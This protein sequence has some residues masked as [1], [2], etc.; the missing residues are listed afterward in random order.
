M[1]T[2]TDSGIHFGLEIVRVGR[3]PQYVD[4]RISDARQDLVG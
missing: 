4:S 1:T 3:R 2:E